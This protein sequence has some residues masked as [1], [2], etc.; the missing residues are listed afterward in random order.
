MRKSF[1]V[2]PFIILMIL[3]VFFASVATAASISEKRQATR[4]MADETLGKLY[5]VHPLAQEAIENSAGYAIFS[6]YGVKLFILGGGRGKGIAVN[7]NSGQE[8][9]MKKADIGVGLGLGIKNYSEVFVF[10]TEKAFNRFV[11]QGWEFGA[12]ATLAATDGVNGGA[13]QGAVSI[14]P[15]AW[16][17]QLT[18]KGLALEITGQGVRYYKDSNLN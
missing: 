4:D 15:G 7:N 16:L 8:V 11:D 9:F 3:M 13:F 1:L 17:Y 12:Q 18:D 6:N 5:K 14:W 10:E 2:R